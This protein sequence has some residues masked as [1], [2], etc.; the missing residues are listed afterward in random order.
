MNWILHYKEIRDQQKKAIDFFHNSKKRFLIYELP[1]WSWKSPL[2]VY[3]WTLFNK[4]YILTS[5]KVLQDQYFKDFWDKWYFAMIKWVKNYTCSLN[6]EN[7][8]N[9]VCASISSLKADCNRKWIC[10]YLEKLKLAIKKQVTNSNYSYFFYINGQWCKPIL[11][12]RDCLICDEAHNLEKEIVNY[13][14]F[15]I[16]LELL[17]SLKLDTKIPYFKDQSNYKKWLI[18]LNKVIEKRKFT[19]KRLIQDIIWR[20][21]E[22]FNFEDWMSD[23]QIKLLQSIKMSSS[24]VKLLD[25]LQKELDFIDKTWVKIKKFAEIYYTEKWIWNLEFIWDSDKKIISWIEFKPITLK[26]ISHDVLF[27]YWIKKVILLSW[28]ILNKNYYCESLWINKNEVDFLRLESDFPK[29][30]RKIHCLNVW[31]LNFEE[32][33]KT[34]PY[35]VKK[36]EE[37]LEKHKNEKWIIH[38]HTYE[39]QNYILNNINPIYKSRFLFNENSDSIDLT[40]QKHKFSNLNTVLLS[41]SMSEWVDLKWKDSEFQIIVKLPYP[42]LWD[43]YV[44]EKIKM[45]WKFML[46]EMFKKF[47]QSCWRSIRSKDDRCETYILDSSINWSLRNWK[48]LIPDWFKESIILNWKI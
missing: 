4:S 21:Y 47:M 29:E 45:N 33:N 32:K 40:I 19:M 12:W 17:A 14:T 10:D 43:K 24:D 30:H 26:K 31:K 15:K 48:D 22:W 41:P 37:I 23:E 25:Q 1:T 7:A 16:D 28:T 6:W 34:L 38:T 9:W 44:K 20:Y 42:Y 18:Q 46:Y 35:I 2:W 11:Y 39:I 27:D 13:V 8:K 36:I 3:L 5:Q